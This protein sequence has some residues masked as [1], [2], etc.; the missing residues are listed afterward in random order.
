MPKLLRI[1]ARETRVQQSDFY[2]DYS[3][4]KRWHERQPREHYDRYSETFKRIGVRENSDILELGFGQGRFLDWA[5]L[6]GHRVEGVEILPEMVEMA[7]ARGHVAHLGPLDTLSIPAKQFDVLAA[8]DVVE[9]LSLHEIVDFFETANQLLR[10]DGIIILQFPNTSSPFSALYQ[11]GDVTHKTWLSWNS[12]Q[13]ISE[14]KDWI[15]SDFFN[16]RVRPH[17]GWHAFKWWSAFVI[18]DLVEILLGFAYYGKRLPMDPNIVAVLRRSS[19][20][21]RRESSDANVLC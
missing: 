7:R 19:I 8:F 18:R 11:T 16:S 2:Q 3:A 4:H 9:H 15:V 14:T 12:L 6:N 21:A 1:N 13:Q 10:R 20:T 17:L 5:R